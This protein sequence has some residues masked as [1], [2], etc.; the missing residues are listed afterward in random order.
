MY[1]D[2]SL[3]GPLLEPLFRIQGSPN[4]L[5]T[6]S[7]AADLG[8]CHIIMN[9]EVWYSDRLLQ[10]QSTPVCQAAIQILIRGLNVCTSDARSG[11]ALLISPF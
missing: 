7:A 5:R 9:V 4:Y 8:A 11:P 2:P 3:G 1:I 10:D 6:S